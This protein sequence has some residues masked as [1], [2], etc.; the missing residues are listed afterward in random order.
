MIVSVLYMFLL[1]LGLLQWLISK[2]SACN[3]GDSGSIPGSGRSSEEGNGN[4]LQYSYMGHPMDRE[5]WW[6]KVHGSQR[7]KHN[8]A[9][10]LSLGLGILEGPWIWD[11]YLY[12][13]EILIWSLWFY[14]F[15][16][17]ARHW[18]DWN[19]EFNLFWSWNALINRLW[20]WISHFYALRIQETN[21]STCCHG[22]SL[23][24][25]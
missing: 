3:T 25:R 14:S 6:A 15:L 5:A 4:P 1:R 12:D 20:S 8:W 22:D 16:I 10:V 21:V 7:V 13:S 2:E 23:T 18:H 11:F 24:V 19:E 17:R 9:T